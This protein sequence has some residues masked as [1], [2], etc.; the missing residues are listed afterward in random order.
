MD[1]STLEKRIYFDSYFCVCVC[2]ENPE[3]LFV[4][5][6]TSLSSSSFAIIRK[7][8]ENIPPRITLKVKCSG[9][10]RCVVDFT[11]SG[12]SFGTRKSLAA[13][14]SCTGNLLYNT[15]AHNPEKREEEEEELVKI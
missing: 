9:R 14:L 1:P 11:T 13:S 4:C 8:T 15:E 7:H 3:K 6:T 12:V 2:V 10:S 5:S